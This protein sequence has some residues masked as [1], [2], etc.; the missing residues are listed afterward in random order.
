[1]CDL[2]QKIDKLFEDQKM[3]VYEAA[4]QLGVS[5]FEVLKHRGKD[6]FKLIGS[7]HLEK[8]FE[9]LSSWGEMNFIKN[10]PEFIIEI[11]VKV[12]SPKKAQGY[13]N[14]CGKSGFL[15]GHLKKDAI[16]NI[17]FASTKFMGMLGHSLHFYGKD[18]NII[19]K[20]YINRDEKHNLDSEQEKKFFA[21]KDSF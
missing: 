10:T 2:K 3:S 15:G 20:L 12:S 7:E 6:E 13:L 9:E 19:F 4:K 5:E 18:N 1:M 14:F 8:I 11:K 17:G 21:L 16:A